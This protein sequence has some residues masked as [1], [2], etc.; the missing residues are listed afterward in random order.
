MWQCSNNERGIN[1]IVIKTLIEIEHEYK[2][3]NKLNKWELIRR[4][5][6]TL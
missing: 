2:D 1:E 5:N 6:S 4:C 3:N